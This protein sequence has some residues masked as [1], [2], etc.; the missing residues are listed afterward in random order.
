M[1]TIKKYA[2]T[3]AAPFVTMYHVVVDSHWDEIFSMVG[4]GFVIGLGFWGAKW[5]LGV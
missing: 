1:D 3:I 2:A 4:A 5:V